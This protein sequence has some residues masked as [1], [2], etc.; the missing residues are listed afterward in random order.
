MTTVVVSLG[1]NQVCSG[2][3]SHA[4]EH[5]WCL[6][7]VQSGQVPVTPVGNDNEAVS[8]DAANAMIPMATSRE[9]FRSRVVLLTHS[10]HS[11][12]GY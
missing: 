3:R 6:G 12:R 4:T 7:A 8:G 10:L 2:T 11:H 9:R 5:L 1:G